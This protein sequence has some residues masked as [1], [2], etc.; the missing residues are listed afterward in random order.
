[1]IDFFYSFYSEVCCDCGT[2]KWEKKVSGV[3]H[4]KIIITR[5]GFEVLVDSSM[6]LSIS[7]VILTNGF[8]SSEHCDHELPM[9]GRTSTI[10]S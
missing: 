4:S 10:Y 2:N 1:M 7:T 9:S 6:A 3:F 5:A 8:F